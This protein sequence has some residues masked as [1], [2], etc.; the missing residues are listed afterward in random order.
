[1]RLERAFERR[2]GFGAL[3]QDKVIVQLFEAGVIGRAS[4][5]YVA[6]DLIGLQMH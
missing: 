5:Q 2:D 4:A 6:I 3:D 1:L